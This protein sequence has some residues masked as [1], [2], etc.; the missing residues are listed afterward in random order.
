M[1][2]LIIPLLFLSSLAF[3]E[4]T[5]IGITAPTKYDNGDDLVEADIDH[6]LICVA[7]TFKDECHSE[8]EVSGNVIELSSLPASTHHIKALT[9]MGNGTRGIYGEAFS[10]PFRKPFPPGLRIKI[11]ING[12]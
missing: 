5:D 7:V 1:K 9:V 8:M 10:E 6:Y 4:I 11:I 12:F 3:A 2:F